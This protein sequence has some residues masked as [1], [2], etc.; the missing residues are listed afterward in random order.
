MLIKSQIFLHK[1]NK[2]KLCLIKTVIVRILEMIYIY[3]CVRVRVYVCYEV[4]CVTTRYF[5]NASSYFY[6]D[7][8]VDEGARTTTFTVHRSVR[9]KLF[10]CYECAFLVTRRSSIARLRKY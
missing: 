4:V 2:N 9:V 5:I 1:K 3:T 8:D 10:L 7:K 6:Q